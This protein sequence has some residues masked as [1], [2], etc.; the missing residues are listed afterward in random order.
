MCTIIAPNIYRKIYFLYDFWRAQT[1]SFRA[2]FRLPSA[3]TNFDNC[4]QRY[5]A[6]CG[7]KL[8]R[9]TSACWPRPTK[10]GYDNVRGGVCF[11]RVSHNLYRKRI[12]LQHPQFFDLL[13][14][15]TRLL[16]TATEFYAVIRL[17]NRKILTGSTKPSPGHLFL[18]QMLT[19]DVFAVANLLVD[20]SETIIVL[21][22]FG[23]F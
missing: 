22:M 13:H 2:I 10:F 23:N 14:A 21:E 20:C 4:C 19:R 7:K 6:T 11:N 3:Y 18:K 17:D 16:H 15:P 9:R 5:I 1:C 8:C 12:K